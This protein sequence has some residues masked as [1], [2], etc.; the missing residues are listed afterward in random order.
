MLEEA[1]SKE[2]KNL[3]FWNKVATSEDHWIVRQANGNL[4]SNKERVRQLEETL[5][6]LYPLEQRQKDNVETKNE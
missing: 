2:R 4:S 6:D 3:D 5:L 1:L